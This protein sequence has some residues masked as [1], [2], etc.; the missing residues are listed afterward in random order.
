MN[1]ITVPA[2]LACV[3]RVRDL[4]DQSG[5]VTNRLSPSRVFDLKV[6]LCE[7]CANAIEHAHAD[8]DVHLWQLDDRV[9]AEVSNVGTFNLGCKGVQGEQT[10][11]FGFGLMVS[12][13][14]EVYI[15][16]KRRGRTTIKLWFDADA[17]AVDPAYGV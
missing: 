17:A 2:D 9:V 16:A 6:A 14:D 8:V 4:V 10:R 1:S 7:A 15:S 5:G 12:L 13:A 11:G 3:S